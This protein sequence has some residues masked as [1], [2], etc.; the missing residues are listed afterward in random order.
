MIGWV[1]VVIALVL[2]LYA[3]AGLRRGLFITVIAAAGFLLGAGLGVRVLPGVVAGIVDAE[4]AN[5]RPFVL[6]VLVLVLGALGQALAVGLARRAHVALRRSPVR[7][8]DSALGGLVTLGVALVVLWFGAGLARLALP[9]PVAQSLSHSQILR[10]VDDVMPSSSE[11]VVA[12]TVVALGTYGFP[13]AFGGVGP[14]PITPVEAAPNSAAVTPAVRKASASILR[15]DALALA[16]DRSQEGT[17]WIVAPGL[18]VTNAHVVA[19]AEQ[20]SVTSGGHRLDAT[21]VAFDPR[22]DLAV[23]SVRKLSGAALPLGPDLTDNAVAAVAGYPEGG[24]YTV[25]AARVRGELRAEGDDIYGASGVTREV[26]ALRAE[27]RPGNSG[28]PLLTPQGA[29]SGVVFARSL[30]DSQTAYALTLAELRPVLS[31]VTSATQRPVGTG[32]CAA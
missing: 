20:V 14:E 12:R 21:V 9:G 23:L 4:H 18:V 17:G 6:L 16:C 7:P 1:D 13:R 3:V 30:D 25:G 10:A 31:A 5:I 27:I 8:I 32:R 24:P 28:G 15:I 26:Y 11:K 19:G 2:L 22:R 29:V